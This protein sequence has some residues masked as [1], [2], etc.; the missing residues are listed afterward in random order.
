MLRTSAHMLLVLPQLEPISAASST[1]TGPVSIH[2]SI[3][4]FSTQFSF[5]DLYIVSTSPQSAFQPSIIDNTIFTKEI[6]YDFSIFC[7][8]LLPQCPPDVFTA[9]AHSGLLLDSGLHFFVIKVLTCV[10]KM[11]ELCTVYVP[12]STRSLPHSSLVKLCLRHSKAINFLSQKYTGHDSSHCFCLTLLVLSKP[13]FAQNCPAT[14]KAEEVQVAREGS[15]E[16]PCVEACQKSK[17]MLHFSTVGPVSMGY[18]SVSVLG[19]FGVPM[20]RMA[21][22]A[23]LHSVFFLTG[24]GLLTKE[25]RSSTGPQVSPQRSSWLCSI[26]ISLSPG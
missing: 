9:A 2:R 19:A 21:M 7:T 8:A 1:L 16:I 23:E 4:S 26:L 17:K 5:Y 3:L 20:E 24:T 15:V 25:S 12:K 14:S 6:F 22:S 18:S 13:S 11:S 10:P